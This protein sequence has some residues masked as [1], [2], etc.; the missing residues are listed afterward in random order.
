MDIC[1]CVQLMRINL[2]D[3]VILGYY[4]SKKSSINTKF[5]TSLA[6]EQKQ[7]KRTIDYGV[8]GLR[9]RDRQRGLGRRGMRKRNKGKGE[10]GSA[11]GE[12]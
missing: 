10:G 5:W 1:F 3:S 12:G 9:N 8:K 11:K 6:C 7:R 2:S 4:I